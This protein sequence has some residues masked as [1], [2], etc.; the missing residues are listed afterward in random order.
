[1]NKIPLAVK[2]GENPDYSSVGEQ[3]GL[4]RKMAMLI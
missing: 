4:V 2:I 1:M 3:M